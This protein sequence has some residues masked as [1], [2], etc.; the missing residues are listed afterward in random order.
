MAIKFYTFLEDVSF[1]R[2]F[3]LNNHKSACCSP[4]LINFK[5]FH[6]RMQWSFHVVNPVFN[7]TNIAAEKIKNETKMP[8][9]KVYSGKIFY[10]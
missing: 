6:P 7:V 9:N 8:D 4:S 10:K 5:T 1:L 2:H 3:D